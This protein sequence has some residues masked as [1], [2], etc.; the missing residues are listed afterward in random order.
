M[1]GVAVVLARQA[2]FFNPVEAASDTPPVGNGTVNAFVSG[3][4]GVRF[5]A[6]RWAASWARLT[7]TE[8]ESRPSTVPWVNTLAS[9]LL[10]CTIQES[11]L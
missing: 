10:N 1:P 11:G 8:D 6:A 4:T 9:V 7:A 5:W 2:R 3:V